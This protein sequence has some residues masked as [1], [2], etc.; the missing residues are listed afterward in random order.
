MIRLSFSYLLPLDLMM[1]S[2]RNAC[3]RKRLSSKQ[4][5]HVIRVQ[6]HT[7]MFFLSHSTFLLLSEKESEKERERLSS[8]SSPPSFSHARVLDSSHPL[9]HNLSYPFTSQSHSLRCVLGEHKQPKQAFL[10]HSIRYSSDLLQ[11]FSLHT[12]LCLQHCAP[13]NH[14]D[15][16]MCLI[17]WRKE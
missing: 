3:K 12:W 5:Q 15:N 14:D 16:K 6:V 10:Q 11:S 9:S 2:S 4:Q 17:M 13:E 8:S 7:H 1:Q